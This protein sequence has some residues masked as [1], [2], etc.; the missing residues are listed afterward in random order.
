MNTKEK[1][2]IF[3]TNM[4]GL[5]SSAMA[6]WLGYYLWGIV[7]GWSQPLDLIEPLLFGFPIIDWLITF[8]LVIAADLPFFRLFSTSS[9]SATRKEKIQLGIRK[10][11]T[12][13][14]NGAVIPLWWYMEYGGPGTDLVAVLFIWTLI[15]VDNL[16]RT[17]LY[18]HR[19]WIEKSKTH[20]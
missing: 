20:D 3:E 10:I 13:L 12:F 8:Q 5:F 2:R 9:P 14:L 6:I 1:R 15:Q 18:L 17:G 7:N 19:T 11:P 4:I 16:Y